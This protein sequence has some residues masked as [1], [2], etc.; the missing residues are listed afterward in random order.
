[1]KLFAAIAAL[2]LLL[3]EIQA[4]RSFAADDEPALEDFTDVCLE[5]L[6]I[7]PVE[8]RKDGTTGFVVGGK[9]SSTL[10][11]T[12]AELNGQTIAELEHEMR[13]GASST[14]G[15]L[16]ADE[17]LLDVLAEDNAYVTETLRTT[18][19]ELALHLRIIAEIG[20]RG[21]E[22]FGYH[23]GR[24]RVTFVYTRGHQDSPFHDGT[25]ASSEATIENLATGK[26]LTYSLLVPQM[27]ERYG[28]YEGKGTPYRV[29]PKKIV[30]VLDFLDANETNDSSSLPRRR[31]IAVQRARR[32]LTAAA[33]PAVQLVAG[34]CAPGE[35][36]V[37]HAE[38]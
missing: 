7:K 11:S 8:P 24:F 13:P 4:V 31:R 35:P 10:I 37:H 22:R 23:G 21:I 28:F 20:L 25:R 18:H 27:I 33:P 17:N 12:L 32:K 34:S 26:K 1:M 29:D 16:G 14:K 6:K 15:F 5:S 19:Q 36:E 38:R 3:V 30:D 9:N 2:S